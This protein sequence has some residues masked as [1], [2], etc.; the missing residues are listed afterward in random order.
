MSSVPIGAPAV[1]RDP[2][3]PSVAE[4]YGGGLVHQ[5][6]SAEL[7]AARW[8][9]SREELDDFAHRSHARATAATRA[10]FFRREILSLQLYD[11]ARLQVEFDADEG[12]RPGADRRAMAS[13]P[14][15][16]R[17]PR[18][19]ARFP[20]LREWRVTAGNSSQVSDG[21]AA[22]LIAS[23]ETAARLG[24]RPRARFSSFAL[25]GSD[26]LL[27]LT[28]PIPATRRA[29]ERASLKLDGVDVVEVN[30]AF[31]SV[32]LVWQRELGV[33]PDWFEEHVN[34]NGGAIA[35]G[36]P[37][38]ATGARLV[39]GLVYELERREGRYGLV[40]ICEG[41]GLA[42]ATLLERIAT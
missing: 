17:D 18:L 20:E 36:H 32:P 29:L 13:L 27:M 19:E 34:P 30:E 25:A 42:N 26:P 41:G 23:R 10:G 33:P 3:P 1:G 16:F 4:R 38:G 39:T 8:N 35:I 40:T 7:L 28:G 11:E 15:A 21:A 22:V 9:I 6:I 14:P 12:I 5:G 31:A 2:T 37:L 24:L